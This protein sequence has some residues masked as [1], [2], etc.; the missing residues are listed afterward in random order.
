LAIFGTPLV[1]LL[2]LYQTDGN[3]ATH[4]LVDIN[5]GSLKK[6]GSFRCPADM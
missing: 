4:F 2:S 1:S 6:Q 3:Y 5:K